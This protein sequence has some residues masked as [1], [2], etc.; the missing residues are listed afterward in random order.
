MPYDVL[1][2]LGSLLTRGPNLRRKVVLT[3]ALLISTL[4]CGLA[5]AN[6]Q[7]LRLGQNKPYNFLAFANTDLNSTSPASRAVVVIHGVRRNA[8]DYYQ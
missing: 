6:Q 3:I 7:L 4:Y 1:W 2:P 8:D 5:S